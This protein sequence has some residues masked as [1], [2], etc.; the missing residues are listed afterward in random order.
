PE[1]PVHD[2]AHFKMGWV[3]LNEADY[4][5]ALHHFESS[6]GSNNDPDLVTS[7]REQTR[8]VNVKREALID[9]VYAYTEERKPKEALPYFRKL[10][11]SR[12]AYL[13]ALQKLAN[14]YFV[15]SNFNAAAMV[16]REITRLSADSELNLDF[17]NR[18]YEATKTAQNFNLVNLDVEAMLRALDGYRFDFRIPKT[19]RDNAEH[20]FEVFA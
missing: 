14:R 19:Q 2:L 10:A 3:Y 11:R 15:K 13:L 5:E 20:D 18:I 6:V 8:L 9:L 12:N 16:Y 1:T 4:K 17:T 7:R